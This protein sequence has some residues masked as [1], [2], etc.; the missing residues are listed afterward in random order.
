MRFYLA[1]L[2][3]EKFM[4]KFIQVLVLAFLPLAASA[5]VQPLRVGVIGPFTGPSSDF[6]VH[7]LNGSSPA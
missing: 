6:G 2:I 7:M 3:Q 5:Q 4:R 1:L